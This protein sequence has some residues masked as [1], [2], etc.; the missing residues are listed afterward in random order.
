[1]LSVK[2]EKKMNVVTPDHYGIGIA[3]L[4]QSDQLVSKIV[5][6]HIFIHYRIH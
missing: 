1:M 4:G 5:A 6:L 3:R 2:E